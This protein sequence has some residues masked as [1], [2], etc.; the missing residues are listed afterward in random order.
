MCF[1]VVSGTAVKEVRRTGQGTIS[2]MS[3]VL[4]GPLPESIS[5]LLL[6]YL[7]DE[8]G[9]FSHI[10]LISHASDWNEKLPFCTTFGV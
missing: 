6:L 1:L 3:D 10:C 2:C 4:K 8:S 5:Q 7:I 9:S